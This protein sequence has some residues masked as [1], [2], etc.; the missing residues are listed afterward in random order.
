MEV[1]HL[2]LAARCDECLSEVLFTEYAVLGLA[3]T[4]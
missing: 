1:F 2:D 3:A 4:A